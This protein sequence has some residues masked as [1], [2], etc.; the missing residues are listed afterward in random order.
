MRRIALLS[1]FVVACDADD[2][3]DTREAEIGW[4]AMNRAVADGHTGFASG[5]EV[6]TDGDLEVPCENGGVLTI[7][8]QRNELDD[9]RLD[10]H[11]A[12]CGVNDVVIDGSVTLVSRL[13]W[14]EQGSFVVVDYEGEVVFD[15]AAS[16]TCVIDASVRGTEVVLED[17]TAAD[18]VV[19]GS[20]CAHPAAE[21]FG[22]P[23][24]D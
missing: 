21:L 22:A 12:G 2:P 5:V 10:V 15:G 11:F 18:V 14:D 9:F 19:Q 24:I 17:F 20:I 6:S 23:T 13:D 16:G 7:V 8:S 4:T 3:V 1:L